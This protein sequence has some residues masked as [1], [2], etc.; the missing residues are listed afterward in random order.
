MYISVCMCVSVLSV[1]I[2]EGSHSSSSEDEADNHTASSPQTSPSPS[3]S[4]PP[5]TASTPFDMHCPYPSSS[6]YSPCSYLPTSPSTPCLSGLEF[7]SPCSPH[8][9]DSVCSSGHVSPLLGPRSQCSGASSPD[10]D[11]ERGVCSSH[12][13]VHVCWS[14]MRLLQKYAH[15]CCLWECD[16]KINGNFNI[17][18]K[19]TKGVCSFC[20]LINFTNKTNT[21]HAIVS[22]GWNVVNLIK[23]PQKYQ[24]YTSKS[25][26][27]EAT[28]VIPCFNCS[29]HIFY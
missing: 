23:E 24:N 16:Q 3:S 26:P 25:V 14:V 29:V 27:T 18:S 22:K 10:C 6:L 5:T 15:I 4:N 8:E 11:Q 1:S 2:D 13:H 20:S 19:Y 12:Q 28:L 17:W 21:N 7:V 9:A